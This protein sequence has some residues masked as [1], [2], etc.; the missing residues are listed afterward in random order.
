MSAE[1]A[2]AGA[3]ALEPG[4]DLHGVSIEQRGARWRVLRE[5]AGGSICTLGIFPTAG[6]A[7]AHATSVVLDLEDGPR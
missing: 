3:R 1:A 6:A 5:L 7:I 4:A 2:H